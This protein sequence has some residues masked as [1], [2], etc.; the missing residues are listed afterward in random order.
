MRTLQSLWDQIFHVSLLLSRLCWNVSTQ[1]GESVSEPKKIPENSWRF[2]LLHSQWKQLYFALSIIC[3][4]HTHWTTTTTKSNS[5]ERK[6]ENKNQLK[7]YLP[8]VIALILWWTAFYISL[9]IYMQTQH[10]FTQMG[11]YRVLSFNTE[12]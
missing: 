3:L 2:L 5:I 4:I 10:H 8:E 9:Y 11:L 7:S 1:R 6:A 12:L